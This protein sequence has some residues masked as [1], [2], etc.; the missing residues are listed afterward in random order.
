[1]KYILSSFLCFLIMQTA[2]GV[3]IKN[4][5]CNEVE[6]KI[7]AIRKTK[8]EKV[9]KFTVKPHEEH[10]ISSSSFNFRTKEYYAFINDQTEQIS[11]PSQIIT[12]QN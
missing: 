10:N 5:S 4:N 2:L 1:M 11:K 6:V 9:T 3:K 12:I 8:Y 7:I